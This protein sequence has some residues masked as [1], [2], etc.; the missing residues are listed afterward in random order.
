MNNTTWTHPPGPCGCLDLV[1]PDPC[2]GTPV[3]WQTR[4][5]LL[6][7]VGNGSYKETKN[8]PGQWLP[9][10]RS[11]AGAAFLS[12]ILISFSTLG[13][14]WNPH[15]CLLV[16]SVWGRREGRGCRFPCFWGE[17]SLFSSTNII[18]I[19]R[20][21]DVLLFPW[22]GRSQFERARFCFRQF[23]FLLYQ[24]SCIIYSFPAG[25]LGTLPSLN[26]RAEF[27]FGLVSYRA[28]ASSAA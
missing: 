24:T 19:P 6:A 8:V 10:P 7:R 12:L 23:Y 15:A 18:F 25:D 11:Y 26:V 20:S 28:P 14:I 27:C 17:A 2:P 1:Y 21:P 9:P 5:V 22:I 3:C 13:N 16:V 4:P